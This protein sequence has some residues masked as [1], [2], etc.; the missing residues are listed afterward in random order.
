MRIFRQGPGPHA[1]ALA[2]A[3]VKLGERVLDIG[4]DEAR[5]FA[6]MAG[7][8][9][10]TGRACV[11]V[12]SEAR[13]SRV[14]AAAAAAGVLVDIEVTAW[15]DLPVGDEEFDLVILDETAGLLAGL[16]PA[17]RL[18]IA[19]EALRALRRGGRLLVVERT[20][21]GW[22]AGLRGTP[23]GTGPFQAEGGV[24]AV[25]VGAGFKP[26]RLLAEREGQRFSEG[27]KA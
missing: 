18:G 19:R 16:E 9:G 26:V 24:L 10:L 14:K 15:P 5:L 4:G 21:K 12:A 3:G 23:G 20:P 27:W 7:K 17:H 11:V 25:L 6:A 13:S 2:M 1:L 22:L 8:V